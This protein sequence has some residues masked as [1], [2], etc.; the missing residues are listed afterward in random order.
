MVIEKLLVTR[1]TTGGNASDRQYQFW[2]RNSLSVDLWSKDVLIQKLI[3]IHN[4]SLSEPWNLVSF[5]QE[6]KYSSALFYEEGTDLFGLVTH[7]DD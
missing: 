5:P 4:N 1:P 3:Y 2:E 7:Y 6:Y